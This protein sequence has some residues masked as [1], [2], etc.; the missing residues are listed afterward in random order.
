MVGVFRTH[1]ARIRRLERNPPNE[2]SPDAAHDASLLLHAHVA[3]DENPV[4]IL[5]GTL[6]RMDALCG[7]RAGAVG[8]ISL[9]A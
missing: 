3:R 1:F 4:R 7:R 6:G 9:H 2:S 5:A 8:R